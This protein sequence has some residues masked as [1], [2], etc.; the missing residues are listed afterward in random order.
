MVGVHERTLLRDV[1]SHVDEIARAE[2][3]TRVTGV[4]VRLGA[5]SHF[6]P[7]HFCEHFDDAA[8]GTLAEGAVVDARLVGDARSA[9]AGDVVVETVELEFPDPEPSGSEDA[10]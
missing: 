8:R 1:M 7:A 9:R 3:A 10:G 2:G 5:L 6:T 4:R